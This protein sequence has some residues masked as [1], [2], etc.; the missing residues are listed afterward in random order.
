[1]VHDEMEIDEG[2]HT[3]LL[4]DA[5]VENVIAGDVLR[6]ERGFLFGASNRIKNQADDGNYLYDAHLLTI[7]C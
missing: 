2:E 4:L 3:L 7:R 6:Y 1:M 5:Q